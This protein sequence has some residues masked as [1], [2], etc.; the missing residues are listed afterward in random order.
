MLSFNFQR[1]KDETTTRMPAQCLMNVT[2]KSGVEVVVTFPI[3]ETIKV[4]TY[5]RAVSS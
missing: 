2:D 4:L 5:L 1:N 3:Q